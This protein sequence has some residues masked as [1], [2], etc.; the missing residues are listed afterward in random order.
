[1]ESTENQSDRCTNAPHTNTQS[2][3]VITVYKRWEKRPGKHTLDDR[4]HLVTDVAE[5]R[6]MNFTYGGSIERYTGNIGANE[7]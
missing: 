7:Q 3:D 6:S 4:L 2:V 5:T 1:M